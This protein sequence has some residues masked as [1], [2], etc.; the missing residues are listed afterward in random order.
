MLQIKNKITHPFLS[1][2]L[3]DCQRLLKGGESCSK[4]LGVVKCFFSSMC[5][6]LDI[7]YKNIHLEGR[8]TPPQTLT[9]I[10]WIKAPFDSNRNCGIP[11]WKAPITPSEEPSCGDWAAPFQ[12]TANSSETHLLNLV[13]SLSLSH[14]THCS[15]RK[16]RLERACAVGKVTG[17]DKVCQGG[18]TP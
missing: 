2:L 16:H 1:P 14:S 4:S 3:S 5:Y 12:I 10:V 11:N 6:G 9:H 8:K 13:N 17:T 18:D 7:A 15:W